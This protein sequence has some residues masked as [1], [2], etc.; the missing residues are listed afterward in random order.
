MNEELKRMAREEGIVAVEHRID[1][2]YSDDRA[3]DA[4]AVSHN[5]AA[6]GTCSYCREVRRSMELRATLSRP[7]RLIQEGN[8]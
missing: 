2:T 1:T 5:I 3:A 6:A 7:R 4:I 8:A